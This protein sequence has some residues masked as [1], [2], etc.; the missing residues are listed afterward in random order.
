[1]DQ[2]VLEHSFIVP[3]VGDSHEK[4]LQRRKGSNVNP[5]RNL[6]SGGSG[7]AGYSGPTLWARSKSQ[8]L[9]ITVELEHCALVGGLLSLLELPP[10][11]T[12]LLPSG[13]ENL[14]PGPVNHVIS[15]VS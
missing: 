4:S 14:S 3:G 13:T 15:P 5:L 11:Y 10:S 12:C 8:P 2:G 7:S 1:M 6:S 9:R